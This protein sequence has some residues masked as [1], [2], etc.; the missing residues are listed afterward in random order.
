MESLEILPGVKVTNDLCLLVDGTVVLGDLHIG[1]EKALEGEGVHLPRI[2]TDTIKEAVQRI[3]DRHQPSRIVLLGDI[4]HDFRRTYG[5]GNRDVREVL[6]LMHQ[7]TDVVVVR[8]NHDNFLA[9]IV[10]DLGIPFVERHSEGGMW[11]VHGHRAFSRRPVVIGH[12]HP[13]IKIF[14]RVGA[15]V[16][17]PCFLHQREEGIVVLP[18]FSPLAAGNDMTG[19]DTPLS[20]VLREV[21]LKDSSVYACSDIGLLSLGRLG[22]LV[23]LR[24]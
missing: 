15:Y 2:Q 18:A 13:S 7:Q 10:S 20:P 3:I 9:G 22:D 23:G 19:N 8:G 16:K 24:L 14:D 1:Y 21:E 6:D 4:K 12:E 11:M 17:L 5:E